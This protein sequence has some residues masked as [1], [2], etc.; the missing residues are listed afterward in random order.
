MP[1][2]TVIADLTPSLPISNGHSEFEPPFPIPNR[3]SREGGNP[4]V[5]A[6]TLDGTRGDVGQLE[7]GLRGDD[8]IVTDAI[9]AWVPAFAGMTEGEGRARP[10]RR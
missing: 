4:C 5:R 8:L 6:C 3:H 1:I 7:H 10:S 9:T 2:S